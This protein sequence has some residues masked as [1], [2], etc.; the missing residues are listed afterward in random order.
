MHDVQQDNVVG[1]DPEALTLHAH[2]S[3]GGASDNAVPTPVPHLSMVPE[4]RD[5][6]RGTLIA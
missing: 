2:V 4:S 5:E 6:T 1:T 3:L